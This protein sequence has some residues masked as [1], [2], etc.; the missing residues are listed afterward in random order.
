[1]WLLSSVFAWRTAQLLL[2]YN[3]SVQGRLP[4]TLS[5]V[6]PDP[7]FLSAKHVVL[8]PAH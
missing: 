6:G 3:P 4:V 5:E 7:V 8:H 2:M 1:V